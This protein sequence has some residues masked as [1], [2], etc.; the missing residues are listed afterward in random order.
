MDGILIAGFGTSD[1]LAWRR[2][3]N[4]IEES[5]Q[6]TCPGQIIEYGIVSTRVLQLLSRKGIKR[7]SM[8]EG[9]CILK[10]KNVK[11]LTILPLFITTGK[12]Y[13]SMCASLHYAAH[14]F[15]KIHIGTPLLY[16]G[17]DIS[18]LAGSLYRELRPVKNRPCLFMGH[19][20][21]TGDNQVYK[22]MEQAFHRAGW[23]NVRIGMLKSWNYSE[24]SLV[25][26]R[27]AGYKTIT[28]RPFLM[29]SGWHV[30]HD[31]MG[32]QEDSWKSRLVKMGFEVHCQ[33][34]GLGEY[35]CVKELL[36]RHLNL[37]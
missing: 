26:W 18:Y 22:K 32:E 27:D 8:E 14:D 24:P 25:E 23:E 10:E 7:N 3:L 19:G 29:S 13:D 31:M 12:E 11:C 5:L 37:S 20:T 2:V 21:D 36:I 34:K 35:E 4:G 6:K 1:E 28:L 30:A 16:T 33:L 15:E 17:E 9:L